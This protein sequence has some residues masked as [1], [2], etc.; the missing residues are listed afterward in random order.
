MAL[1][2]AAIG[3][4]ERLDLPDAVT[5]AGIDYLVA[6]QLRHLRQHPTDVAA[7]A[8]DMAAHAVAEQPQEANRQHYELPP[9]F[10][11]QV[12]GPRRK[13]SSC[14]YPQGTESL[15][16]AEI[17]ALDQT[18]AHAELAD[19][20]QILELGCG[21]GSL[22]LAMAE[23]FPA[24][25]ITAVSNSRPQR[26]HILSEAVRRN[27]T[28]VEVITAD[29]NA[30]VPP[31]RYDRVVSVEMFEHMSNWRRLLLGVRQWLNPGGKLFIHIFTHANAP[32][33]FD[34]DS[35]TD[36]IAHHFFAGGLMPSHDLLA[37]FDDL[38]AM[39][40]Q[41]RW[42]GLHY[43]RT[44]LQWLAN[45]DAHRTAIDAILAKV[46][47]PEA[48]LWRRRWRLFF[49]ATAGLFGHADG[50]EWGVSHYLLR[51]RTD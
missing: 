2:S 8:R 4:V 6:R 12:L 26:R 46:Y 38:F 36:W 43:Q 9:E 51:Q 50:R 30:F 31:G 28:N 37:Q 35:E 17:A 27:L 39:E 7:F 48:R 32:Y 15:E 49:L 22:T 10:F 29:M 16:A 41:W 20:Q 3:A 23:R 18:I 34:S 42:S 47:G 25:R 19:G 13:Y 14:L 44:A 40:R 24:A 21:W 1:L 5:R 33:R 11:G 45:F